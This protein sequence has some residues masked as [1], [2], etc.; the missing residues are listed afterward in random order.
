MVFCQSCFK[1]FLSYCLE[2]NG[3]TLSFHASLK[4]F[5]RA[6]QVVCPVSYNHHQ[7]V[8][9]FSFSSSKLSSKSKLDI[10]KIPNIKEFLSKSVDVVSKQE[11]DLRLG[12]QEDLPPYLENA[13]YTDAPNGKTVYF[14]TYGCQM[15]VNDAEY[16][17]AVL[18][19]DGYKRVDD[20][21]KACFFLTD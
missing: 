14:E 18:K 13:V 16:A 2:R 1:N 9:F 17:W 7:T 10:S 20:L 6:K 3:A 12:D 4:T 5:V 8:R 11:I 21:D 15:N 19:S